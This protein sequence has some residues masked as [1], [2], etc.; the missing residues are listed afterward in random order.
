MEYNKV[1]AKLTGQDA[2]KQKILYSM[3]NQKYGIYKIIGNKGTGK[4][5][6]CEKI[7]DAWVSQIHG[8]VFYFNAVYQEIIEDYSTFKNFIYRNSKEQKLLDIFNEVLKDVPYIGNSLSAVSKEISSVLEQQKHLGENY[9]QNE[10]YIFSVIKRLSCN[11][12]I[13]FLCFDFEL[14]DLQ[15]QQVL[16]SFVKLIQN[17]YDKKAFFIFSSSQKEGDLSNST[18]KNLYLNEISEDDIAEVIKQFNP[19]IC[20]SSERQK[21]IYDLT[22][23]NLEL[24]RESLSLF[25]INIMPLNYDF[26]DILK[27]DL[28]KNFKDVDKILHLLKQTAFVGE[29]VDS[30]LLKV[31]SETAPELYEQLVGEAI[32]HCYL[33]E[34]NYT[35][36]FVKKYIYTILKDK[37]NKNRKY[38]IRLM[39]CIN[40]L[41]PSRYDLQ[42]YYLYRGGLKQQADKMFLIYLLSYYREN[43]IIYNLSNTDK[44]ALSQNPLFSTYEKLCCCYQLYKMK[45]YDET[46]DMLL[47][48]YCESIEFRFEKDYLLSLVVT[49]KYFTTEEFQERIDV[50]ATYI[51]EEFYNNHPEMY[52]RALMMLAEFYAETINEKDLRDC[53]RKINK[54]FAQYSASDKQMQCYEHCFKLKANAFYKIE[55]ASKYIKDA[56]DYFSKS[57]NRKVY[58]SK[59]YLSILNYSANLIVLGNYEESYN[60]LINALQIVRENPYLKNIHEDIL[61]NNLL[62][63]SCLGHFFSAIECAGL[64]DNIMNKIVEAADNILVQNNKAAF[65]ALAG[66]YESALLICSKLYDKIQ[67]GED[68]DNYYRYFV[69]NNYGIILWI[70]KK[71]EDALKVL[72]NAFSVTPLLKDAAYFNTRSK[73]VLSLVED[74]APSDII[75]DDNWNNHLYRQNPNIVG[76]AWKFWSS[77]LLFS[78]LQIWSDF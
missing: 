28:E 1:I 64:L 7:A 3:N 58:I 10:Q 41:Y 47:N 45:K 76:P 49:N 50:L 27:S 44:L 36:S 14:W 46:E 52:L 6:L 40:L 32:N 13:L 33:Q 62:I 2:I 35:I 29:A 38:Y 54:S 72:S 67:Y 23:G 77:L 60:L 71:N 73:M 66:H 74:I 78:E 55:I 34:K 37:L 19:Q 70:C 42:M 43:N 26:Y 39:K 63:S 16:L 17:S 65:L 9:T 12:N 15:S 22:N 68:I 8:K 69:S 31:F 51:T 11:S 21:H 61:I 24:I 20:L 75:S 18:V 53:L 25:E 48:L 30:R 4:R 57:E 56:F 5:T 59:Y